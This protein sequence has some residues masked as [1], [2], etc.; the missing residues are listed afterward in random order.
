MI[1]Q[2]KLSYVG[3]WW[4]FRHAGA[5]R[6]TAERLAEMGYRG[7]DWKET[8]FCGDEPL[9]A[10]WAA[11]VRETR[12]AG[13]EVPCGVIL[14]SYTD[15]RT[16]SGHVADICRFIELCAE[17]GVPCVNTGIGGPAPR[18]TKNARF[19]MQPDKM[20]GQAWDTLRRATEA[21]AATAERCR[22]P[23]VFESVVG[24]LVHDYFTTREMF[25]LFDSPFLRLTLDPS[26]YHLSDND[27]PW[28]VR[29]WGRAKIGHVHL[30]DAVGR[31]SGTGGEFLF[32]LLGEGA[33]N[34][35]AFFAALDDIG[36]DGWYAVEFESD[37][38]AQDILQGDPYE[39]A[40]LSARSALALIAR[41][42]GR[43]QS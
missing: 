36:Y 15:P 38:Y 7:V 26:H 20:D 29:Q 10:Q 23:V 19:W 41:Y 40:R 4:Q 9:A 2:D 13:L 16:V 5:V 35:M 25:R 17:T 32:P 8:C 1:S 37:K 3:F 28:C 43:S 33:I 22:T 27:I 18:D 24:N 30:K 39:A 11:A 12:L 21:I 34:W 14:R 42:Q 6:I 31:L